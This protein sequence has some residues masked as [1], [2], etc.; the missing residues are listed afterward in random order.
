MANDIIDA[1]AGA[2]FTWATA[3]SLGI[4]DL[5]LAGFS[6]SDVIYSMSGVEVTI[7]T[8]LSVGTLAVAYF[9]NDVEYSMLD[10]E[11]KV[12]SALTI[13]L[14]ALGALTSLDSLVGGSIL[15]A[16]AILGISGGGYWALA[17]SD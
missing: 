6:F 12:L 11:E 13:G 5:D 3:S 1:T 9:V 14:V 16:L 17:T 4:A 8:A 10:S 7:A 2:L 15:V